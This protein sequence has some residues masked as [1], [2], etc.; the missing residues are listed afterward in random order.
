MSSIPPPPPLPPS[1]HPSPPHLE[2][3]LLAPRPHKLT[4]DLP[5]E[6]ARTLDNQVARDLS[7][8]PPPP[9]VNHYGAPPSLPSGSHNMTP[10]FVV[11]TLSTTPAPIPPPGDSWTPWQVPKTGSPPSGISLQLPPSSSLPYPGPPSPEDTLTATMGSLSVS[12]PSPKKTSEPPSLT[13]SLPTISSLIAALPSVQTPTNTPAS[14]IAWCRDV[15]G[16]VDRLY[17]T[18]N[19]TGSA[20]PPS[21][22]IHVADQELNRLVEIAVP[23][24]LQY[25]N[26]NPVPQQLP[27][28]VAEALYLR[29]KFESTGAYP[30]F[31]PQN[32]RMAFRDYER[33]ARAGY[34]T[35]WFK[36]GRDY[37]NFGDSQHAKD[38]YER[39]IRNNN[40]SC[41]YRM[42]MAHLVG[43]LGLPANTEVALPLLQR[44]AT[45]A[46]VD[47]PQPAYVFGLLLLGEFSHAS[48]PP[49]LFTPL[50]PPGSSRDNE[51]RRH[52]E[53]AAYLN[54]AA[55]QYKLGH[56]Y[57]FAQPPFPFDALLSVQYYSLA[58]QQGEIEADM[59]LSKWFLCGSEGAFDKDESLAFTFAEKAARKGL[60]SAEFAMGYYVEVGVGGPKDIEAARKWYERASQHGNADATERLAALSQPAPVSLSRQEHENLTETTLVRKRTQAKQRS[61]ASGSGAGPRTGARQNGQQVVAVIRQSSLAHRPGPG[62]NPGYAAP[63]VPAMLTQSGN[64]P[65]GMPPP[66]VN[67]GYANPHRQS[68]MG[69]PNLNSEGY[70]QQRQPPPQGPPSGGSGFRPMSQHAAGHQ[71][72]LPPPQLH[73]SLP[74]PQPHASLPPPGSGQG[75]PSPRMSAY[76]Q[77]ARPPQQQPGAGPSGP[78]GP[79][80]RRPGPPRT[81]SGTG[82]T[83]LGGG[84]PQQSSAPGSALSSPGVYDAPMKPPGPKGPATFQEMGFQSEK[85]DKD[86]CVIM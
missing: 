48:V 59:A 84:P 61:D 49:H 75:Y 29:A 45:L 36:I 1:Y 21:G 78:G 41:L 10:G 14:K 86:N 13:A 55:A 24:V 51:A 52:L 46:T 66:P 81:A 68:P 2:E 18:P 63:P 31:I 19:Q 5:A 7:I 76:G 6:M 17:V 42:G 15:I 56:A 34:S 12:G 53:R 28:H 20:D 4:P 65:A 23:M 35:A 83:F 72:T 32:S 73:A 33:A 69:S 54:F 50:I 11:P 70:P 74:P 26:P 71:S 44:A 25:A 64:P 82:P 58:S 62:P 27:L 67:E 16:L 80:G 43:Q 22:P 60:P 38:C 85:L 3:P 8:P 47:S 9:G 77:G 37:E 40:E 57:E 79:G 30:Q 39:G